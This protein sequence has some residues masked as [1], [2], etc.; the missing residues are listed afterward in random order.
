MAERRPSRRLR[1]SV[2][3]LKLYLDCPREY[4]YQY[5]APEIPKR[6]SYP[7]LCG[8]VVHALVEKLYRKTKE[9]RT[10]YFKSKGSLLGAWSFN[11]QRNVDLAEQ[12]GQIILPDQNIVRSYYRVGKE[13]LANY[14]DGNFGLPRPL[15]IEK[16]YLY[17]V[18]PGVDLYGI[19]DQVRAAPLEYIAK[20]RP[21]LVENG[22]LKEGYDPVVIVDM[23]TNKLGYDRSLLK[24]VPNLREQLREQYALHEDLQATAYTWLYEKVTGRRPIGFWW[25]HLRSGTYYATFREPKDYLTLY[26]VIDHFLDNLNVQSFPKHIDYHC[27][28][29]DFLEPCREDRAFYISK[30][31]ALSDDI[32]KDIDFLTV[33]PLVA[34][35]DDKQLRFKRLAVPRVKR[36]L[37]ELV[38]F[39]EKQLSIRNLPWDER[40]AI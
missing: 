6:T 28:W 20:F 8:A 39:N 9:P 13:C 22:Q 19:I 33:P 18:A 15:A 23:K 27:K 37:P 29:C 10:F 11:W 40:E 7:R 34:K 30:P 35:A 26:G 5:L 14:W 21:E 24:R 1:I 2:T 25:Y 17:P 38:P 4:F 16:D 12:E 32:L 3:R 36:S 31:R